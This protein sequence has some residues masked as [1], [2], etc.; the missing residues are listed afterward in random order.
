M[1]LHSFR[2]EDKGGGARKCNKPTETSR[3]QQCCYERVQ[4][5]PLDTQV[6]VFKSSFSTLL[7]LRLPLSNKRTCLHAS[8]HPV[9]HGVTPLWG[10]STLFHSDTNIASHNHEIQSPSA[11]MKS[12][13]SIISRGQTEMGSR[14]ARCWQG[15]KGCIWLHILVYV[16][17]CV[18]ACLA[19]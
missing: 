8:L 12:E 4:D 17:M 14:K 19:A 7:L 3:H 13:P 9:P 1:C 18:Y 2:E 5:F 10:P 6:T 11:G 15:P 16:L